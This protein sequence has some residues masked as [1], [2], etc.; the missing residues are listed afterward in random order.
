MTLIEDLESRTAQRGH[1]KAGRVFKKS[2]Q[3]W[4]IPDLKLD[5]WKFQEWDYYSPKAALPLMAR[6]LFTVGDDIVLRG[7]N[8]F[9]SVDE[10]KATRLDTLKTSTSGPYYATLKENGFLVMIG[11]YKGKLIVTSKNSSGPMESGTSGLD[12]ENKERNYSWVA[13]ERVLNHLKSVDKTEKEF[14]DFLETNNFTAVGE[15]CDD[16]FEEHVLPYGP[17][18]AG[19]YLNGLNSNTAEFRTESPARVLEIATKYGFKP[20]VYKE[21]ATFESLLEFLTSCAVTG[22]Y[23]G[24]EIEGFVVRCKRTVPDTNNVEDFFF[25][26]KFEEPYLMYREWREIAKLYLSQGPVVAVSTARRSKH[27]E[28]CLRLISFCRDYFGTNEE[29]KSQFLLQNTGI[30]Q[31]RNAFLKATN[32]SEADL[33]KLDL[34]SQFSN[35]ETKYLLVTVSTLGCG[36][37]TVAD[38]LVKLSKDTWTHRQNDEIKAK[39]KFPILVSTLVDDFQN[40]DVAI[41]DRNN[42]SFKERADII[43]EFDSNGPA[44][45]YNIKYVC[46][47]FLPDG[48][49]PETAALTR[50]RVMERGNNHPTVKAVDL[51]YK[52]V[53]KIINNF[54]ARMNPVD[55]KKEPDSA[56]DLV[57]NLEP[58]KSADN[59]FKI[60]KLMKKNYP[61]LGLTASKK[62]ADDAVAAIMAEEAKRGAE[63]AAAAASAPP[64]KRKLPVY[65]GLQVPENVVKELVKIV[66]E[67]VPDLDTYTVQTEMH[68]TL[69]HVSSNKKELKEF[70]DKYKEGLTQNLKIVELGWDKLAVAFKVETEFCMNAIPHITVAH[71][72]PPFYS[73]KMLAGP[74]KSVKIDLEFQNLPVK[75]YY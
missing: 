45:G 64:P 22:Q 75:A 66:R 63:V 27:S 36:K 43:R 26:Y 16:S 57:I 5:R 10:V 14:A 74:H 48:V 50:R 71:K 38:A 61:N 29:L 53:S 56:F 32:L 37:S 51:T 60:M 17:E 13:R 1:P 46:L 28:T 24:R 12:L 11:G 55:V 33:L 31:M 68:V 67:H 20:T 19:I 9:F 72:V 8:K 49:T 2:F 35:L 44:M 18:I 70:A 52:G 40:H 73:N 15:C 3:V 47:N 21:F 62:D 34:S 4:G 7:Y 25:K 30:V 69:V 42:P 23:E 41:L 39:K 54:E 59:V 58:G 6:G 65:F